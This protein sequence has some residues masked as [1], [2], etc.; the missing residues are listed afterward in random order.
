MVEASEYKFLSRLKE[1]LEVVLVR[2][3]VSWSVVIEMTTRSW[4]IFVRENCFLFFLLILFHWPGPFF[5]FSLSQIWSLFFFSFLSSDFSHSFVSK[6]FLVFFLQVL[7][8]Y[9]FLNFSM[10]FPPFFSLISICSIYKPF[11]IYLFNFL[12]FLLYLISWS[13]LFFFLDE[14]KLPYLS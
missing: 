6:W 2:V 1:L 4:K 11:S 8:G 7:L 3:N 14:L 10:W 12:S 13:P 5:S 9:S